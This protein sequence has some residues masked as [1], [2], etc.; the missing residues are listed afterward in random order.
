MNVLLFTLE[1]PPFKG[2]VSN[3]YENLVSHWPEQ[4]NIFVLTNGKIKYSDDGRVQYRALISRF[5]YPK[6]ILGI[7]YLSYNLI[8]NKINHILVGHILPL[9]LIACTISKFTKINYSTIIHGMDFTFALKKKRKRFFSKLILKNSQKII[10]G[11]NYV[12]DMVKDFLGKDYFSRIITVNPGINNQIERDDD[13]IQEIKQKYN[14]KNKLVLFSI[15]RL[16]KRKGFDKVVGLMEQINEAIPNL[17]Y[18]LAGTGP[19]EDYIKNCEISPSRVIYIDKLSD[20]EKW[21]WLSLCDIFIMPSRNINGDFEGFGIVFL[22]ANL[23]GKPVIAGNSGGVG[24]AVQDQCSGLLVNP[25]S[26][27]DIKK[28]IIKLASNED[29]RIKLGLMGQKRAIKEFNWPK[30]INKIYQAII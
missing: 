11:N 2:G 16:V 5:I 14:L 28:A 20:E 15:G 21:S 7:F 30:Q 25:E 27:E 17:Q 19:D 13:L 22:E 1:Y 6:W 10:C 12:A 18:V 8:F 9:G 4:D 26:E 24:D 3:Y 23:A 29:L